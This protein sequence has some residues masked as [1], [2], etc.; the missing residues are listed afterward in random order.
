MGISLTL[1]AFVVVVLGGMGNIMGA[2]FGGFIVGL[3]ES[4]SAGYIST[5]FQDAIVFTVLFIVLVLRPQGLLSRVQGEK[6]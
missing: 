2:I 6:V 5:G 3:I 4:F 1:K